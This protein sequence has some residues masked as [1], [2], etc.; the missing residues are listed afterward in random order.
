MPTKCLAIALLF[1]AHVT[2]TA[3]E[4][5]AEQRHEVE[6]LLNFIASTTCI[7]DRNGSL[8]NGPEALVHIKRKY[9]YYRDDISSTEQFIALS[10]SQSTFSG[11][12][13]TVRCGRGEVETTREWLLGELGE[14]RN[15]GFG[16]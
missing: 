2:T 12:A 4:V 10:A 9:A 15:Q 16:M 7:I 8:H 5:P 13:Y 14:Y 3:A 1:A 11:K 6:H